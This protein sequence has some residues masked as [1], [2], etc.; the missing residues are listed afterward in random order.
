M[1]RLK[2]LFLTKVLSFSTWKL[3]V[4]QS[5]GHVNSFFLSVFIQE[6]ISAIGNA[7]KIFVSDLCVIR[8]VDEADLLGIH[9]PG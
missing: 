6:I 2:N 9:F 3:I 7:D 1:V 5:D 8:F 4:D